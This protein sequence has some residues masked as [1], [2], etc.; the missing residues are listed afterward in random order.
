MFFRAP[1]VP[2]LRRRPKGA[3]TLLCKFAYIL[4]VSL[5][6]AGHVAAEH[7]AA[8]DYPDMGNVQQGCAG[9][10][11]CIIYLS[12]GGSVTTEQIKKDLQILTAGLPPGVGLIAHRPSDSYANLYVYSDSDIETLKADAGVYSPQLG[13]RLVTVGV[14]EGVRAMRSAISAY[15]QQVGVWVEIDKFTPFEVAGLPTTKNFQALISYSADYPSDIQT[16]YST[17]P[18]DMVKFLSQPHYPIIV[19]TYNGFLFDTHAAAIN[20]GL[21]AA[22]GALFPLMSDDVEGMQVVLLSQL[23]AQWLASPTTSG[24]PGVTAPPQIGV[25]APS[26]GGG[27]GIESFPS[28]LKSK[29]V[30]YG[31]PD[32][33]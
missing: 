15:G 32:P 28:W 20:L 5:F 14:S 17:G 6:A 26:D 27:I 2:G 9:A 3:P 4:A 21:V 16:Q 23:A 18:S 22:N 10:T 1:S 29:K 13:S 24:G 11:Q 19:G 12:G 31:T 30:L 7:L 33:H 25:G 8:D